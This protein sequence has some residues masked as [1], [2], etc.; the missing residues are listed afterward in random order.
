MSP[1]PIGIVCC[2]LTQTRPTAL[3]FQQVTAC[4]KQQPRCPFTALHET[5][6]MQQLTWRL[7]NSQQAIRTLVAVEKKKPLLLFPSLHAVK[8]RSKSSGLFPEVWWGSSDRILSKSSHHISLKCIISFVLIGH[9]ITIRLKN[10]KIQGT[11]AWNY[12]H[13][14]GE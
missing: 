12:L 10:Y 5:F 1:K 2:C 3:P 8:Q 6:L 11:W 9:S 14:Q 13:K 7:A 4:Y